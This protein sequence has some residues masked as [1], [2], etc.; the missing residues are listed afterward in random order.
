MKKA[1]SDDQV[2]VATQTLS[3]PLKAEIALDSMD[4]ARAKLGVHLKVNWEMVQECMI[5]SWTIKTREREVLMDGVDF[6]IWRENRIGKAAA[7]VEWK[8]I[9]QDP[10]A[11]GYESEGA[12]DTLKVW[13]VCNKERYRDRARTWQKMHSRFSKETKCSKEGQGDAKMTEWAQDDSDFTFTNM[14]Y[15]GVTER[16]RKAQAPELLALTDTGAA[17]PTPSPA[18][19]TKA[20]DMTN[21]PAIAWQKMSEKEL[22]AV[23]R[24][25]TTTINDMQDNVTKGAL[26]LDRLGDNVVG[27]QP[28]KKT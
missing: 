22:P 4:E 26:L 11:K 18:K 17:T 8:D 5:N 10:R 15:A 21:A 7:L 1:V 25:V 14:F 2:I 16:K 9:V 24:S 27:G 13:V 20:I 19:K 23:R 6:V 3:N 28:L 12:G